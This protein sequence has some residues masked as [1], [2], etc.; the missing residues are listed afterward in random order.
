[1]K[2]SRRCI[3]LI[4]VIIAFSLAAVLIGAIASIYALTET[5][6]QATVKQRKKAFL[7]L[8]LQ[9][10]LNEVITETMLSFGNRSFWFYTSQENGQ[11]S[12]VFVYDNKVDGN[13]AFANWVLAKLFIS[14]KK[15]LV[16]ASW[17][18]PSVDFSLNP[19]MRK[20]ILAENIE[21]LAFSFYTPPDLN[22]EKVNALS[23]DDWSSTWDRERKYLPPIMEITLNQSETFSFVLPNSSKTV[24]YQL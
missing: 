23:Y 1:M 9:K 16:L 18:L 4:E 3:T 21:S 10:R 17:P 22:I 5:N 19:P 12:L 24:L 7:K 15:E 13:P 6:Y 20:E 11:P 8:V 14:E 2:K